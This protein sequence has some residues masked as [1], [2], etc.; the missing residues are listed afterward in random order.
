MNSWKIASFPTIF[1]HTAPQ[2]FCKGVMPIMAKFASRAALKSAL[3][4]S[5][6]TL[7]IQCGTLASAVKLINSD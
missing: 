1:S 7:N 2:F 6:G 5:L 3:E 4:S